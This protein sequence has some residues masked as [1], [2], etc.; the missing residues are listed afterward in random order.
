LVTRSEQAKQRVTAA[1]ISAAPEADS[2]LSSL[3]SVL[4]E[5]CHLAEAFQG[6]RLGYVFKK[7]G[8]GLGYYRDAREA[9]KYER[10]MAQQRGGGGATG[11][12]A[13]EV[14][15]IGLLST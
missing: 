15:I 14:F 5:E 12:D 11:G 13:V 9:K 2:L 1:A 7:G 6:P 4:T 8:E 3:A 10:E